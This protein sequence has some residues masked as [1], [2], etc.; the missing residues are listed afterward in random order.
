M[1]TPAIMKFSVAPVYA[2]L[3][4]LAF[5]AGCTEKEEK[6]NRPEPVKVT[7]RQIEQLT[8]LQELTYSGTIEPDNTAQVGFAVPGVVDNVAVQEGQFVQH[9]QL[10]ASIDATE[11]NNALAIAG[12]GLEQ[13][14]DMFNRLNELYQKGSLPAKDFI[15]IKTK[16]VQAKANKSINA[17][18]IAD[19]RLYAPMAGIVTAKLVVK[20]SAAAPGVPAFTIIKTDRVYATISVPESEVGSLVKGM[21]ATVFIATLKD[22][23]RGKIT[24]INPQADVTSKTYT[25]KIQLDNRTQR[26]LPGMITDVTIKPGKTADIIA[27]PA[28]AVVRDADDITFVYTVNP[29][30][31]AVR[32]RILAG[33]ATG[34][35]EIIVKE[36]L[37]EG[38]KVITAGQSRLKDGIEVKF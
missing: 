31:K 8:R 16:L 11:Y 38:D 5:G 25:V 4:I 2:S 20:G 21:D 9:G 33:N 24:I 14:E 18:H 32:K 26:L 3:I 13:A 28:T 29:Q 23:V 34:K 6:Q 19:S 27:I 1:Q 12:A 30:N 17:K 22:S 35:E 37:S 36:G 15:D 10:L 7:I